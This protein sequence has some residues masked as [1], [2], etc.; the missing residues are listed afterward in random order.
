MSALLS[1]EDLSKINE[2]FP[3]GLSS[4]QIVEI[5]QNKGIK[6][7]EATFRKYVQ[8][9]LV[10]RC[11]RVGRKGKHRGSHGLYPTSTVAR[12]NSIKKM[13]SGDMTL[14]Q[15][16]GSYFSMRQKMEDA[17]RKVQEVLLDLSEHEKMKG[18]KERHDVLLGREIENT[19][20]NIT[21]IINNLQKLE[22][23]YLG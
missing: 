4:Q 21:K 5:F 3:E 2:K 22:E 15:L 1:Q 18:K 12:I 6:F 8:M 16:K 14:E 11:K 7:S 10:E 20:K 17:E 23:T 19:S 13:I 9:G